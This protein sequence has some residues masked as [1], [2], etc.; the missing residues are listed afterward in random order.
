MTGLEIAASPFADAVNLT[1]EPFPW[2][3][4]T[5]AGVRPPGDE[6]AVSSAV[7]S[8]LPSGRRGR[9]GRGR[10]IREAIH[11]V[12]ERFDLPRRARVLAEAVA[13]V[14]IGPPPAPVTLS[15]AESPP[16]YQRNEHAPRAMAA[17][18]ALRVARPA[19]P[20]EELTPSE[21]ARPLTDAERNQVQ[22]ALAQCAATI[23]EAVN[24]CRRTL[25]EAGIVA[26]AGGFAAAGHGQ[27]ES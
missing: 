15:L 23:E 20:A 24:H 10:D 2:F 19:E 17:A 4:G 3:R 8:G 11:H 7:D 27:S 12:W 16:D 14:V 21:E 6:M 13:Q 25:D 22:W 26:T 5:D 9:S 1:S 18:V